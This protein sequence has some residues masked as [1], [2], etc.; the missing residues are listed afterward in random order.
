MCGIAGIIDLEGTR[1]VDR[2]ALARM[3]DGLAHRGPDGHGYHIEPGFGFGHRRLAIIDIDGGAQPFTSSVGKTV[4]TFNGE[5]YNFQI[6]AAE[7][8]S[9]SRTL[10]THSD[11]EVLSELVDIRGPDALP[12][13]NGMFAFASYSPRTKRFLI[14]RDRLGEKPLYYFAS[15]DGYLHFASEMDALLAG[16]HAPN[17]I[18]ETAVADYLTY[19]YVPDPKT[20]YKSIH[21]LAAGH[22][23]DFARGEG[24]PQQR[25]WWSIPMKPNPALNYGEAVEEVT[26]LVD[27]AVSDQMIADVPLAGFLSGGVDSSAIVSAMASLST[28]KITTCAMGFDDPAHDERRFAQLVADLYG[29]DHHEHLVNVDAT[30]LIPIVASVYGE[31]FA[32]SSA[33]PTL[34]LCAL[35][36]RHATVAL[37]GDGGDEVFAGYSRYD[38]ILKESRLRRALPWALRKGIASPLGNRYPSGNW[39]PRQFRLRTALQSV[40]DDAG[41]GY[42]RAVAAVLPDQASRMLTKPLRGYEPSQLVARLIESADT[43]DPV[44]Q[45]Q[46]ADLATWLPGRMLVKVDRASMANGLEV[47]PPLLDY[48]LVEWAGRLPRSFKLKG[49]IGKRVFKQALEPDLPREILYRPKQGFGSPMDRWLRA[50][51]GELLLHLRNSEPWKDSGFFDVE[52]ILSVAENHENNT[53][54]NGQALWSVLMFNAFLERKPFMPGQLAKAV[55]AQES[56]SAARNV[57]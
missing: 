9:E 55:T 36:R 22:Y 43:D 53:K 44:L 21:R 16:G 50:N 15:R 42:A 28:A 2:A 13:L 39:L 11:T 46:F 52:H 54:N 19:G 14:A 26:S 17:V 34:M 23:L 27:R 56:S 35:A 18:D 4:L 6:L 8:R 29:T 40:G 10:R 3:T 47:R 5:I 20:I 24:P 1:E 51:N 7:L 41:L 25:R 31:P 32:D 57:P 37:S 45:A 33:L 38:G 30:A 12:A 48:R 49:G